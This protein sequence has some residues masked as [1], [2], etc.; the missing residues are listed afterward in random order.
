[1]ADRADVVPLR[2]HRVPEHCERGEHFA[3]ALDP[4]RTLSVS[5]SADHEAI[6]IGIATLDGSDGTDGGGADAVVLRADEV[7]ALVRALVER[8]PG[9]APAVSRAPAA[10]IPLLPRKSQA[11]PEDP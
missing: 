4:A 2:R 9:S 1:M 6:R 11:L 3:D 5:W 8:L 10:V 7:L